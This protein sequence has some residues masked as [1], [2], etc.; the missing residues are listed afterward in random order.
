MNYFPF[1]S[2]NGSRRIHKAGSLRTADNFR[3]RQDNHKDRNERDRSDDDGGGLD[4]A[5]LPRV[6]KSVG[7]PILS[8]PSSK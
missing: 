3:I 2:R 5:V 1:I 6:R 4:R 8:T 7:R